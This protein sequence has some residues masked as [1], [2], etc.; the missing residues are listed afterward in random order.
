LSSSLWFQWIRNQAGAQARRRPG[1]LAR[2]TEA[3][4]RAAAAG[5]G[6]GRPRLDHRAA[7]GAWSPASGASGR[8]PF[9]MA[10][11]AAERA[12]CGRRGSPPDGPVVWNEA[13]SLDSAGARGVTSASFSSICS[14]GRAGRC[15]WEQ[16][17]RV[18][19]HSGATRA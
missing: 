14:V 5:L 10:C 16:E 13:R 2:R 15:R 19:G 12:R 9:S 7:G 18:D 4:A 6:A 3:L 11:R 17:S 1:W 8:G